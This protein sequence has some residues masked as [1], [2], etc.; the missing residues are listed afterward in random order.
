M[1]KSILV[2]LSAVATVIAFRPAFADSHEM[3][4]TNSYLVEGNY[5]DPG[6]MMPPEAGMKLY[7]EAIG[8]SLKMLADWE[9]AGKIKGGIV[10]GARAGIFVID[11]S[12]NAAVDKMIQS[13]PFWMML[14]WT[15]TPLVGYQ[16]R[17]DRDTAHMKMM[18]EM[19][20]KKMKK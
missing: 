10:L 8:P 4:A 15:I 6:A 14:D 18:K 1:A 19:M 20:Q 9:A 5:I 16:D 17:L 7:D 3:Q 2:A 12:S 13:L 11:A